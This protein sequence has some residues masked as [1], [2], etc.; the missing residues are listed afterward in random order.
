M[1]WEPIDS[2]TIEVPE[3]YRN[4]CLAEFTSAADSPSVSCIVAESV[5]E[6][7]AV[8]PLLPPEPVPHIDVAD[9][10]L[11][12]ELLGICVVE[13]FTVVWAAAGCDTTVATTHRASASEYAPAPCR[14]Q[15][16]ATNERASGVVVV[17]SDVPVRIRVRFSFCPLA[18]CGLHSRSARWI[19]FKH[20]T[21]GGECRSP[22]IAAG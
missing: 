18:R 22:I 17:M 1:D 14:A 5:S 12:L 3:L 9:P 11:V 10:P 7:D 6:E 19:S 21:A 15:R 20:R 13:E 16:A 4:P 8:A 2:R